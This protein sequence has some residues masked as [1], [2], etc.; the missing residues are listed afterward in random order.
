MYGCRRIRISFSE[1]NLSSQY[2]SGRPSERDIIE[3]R[4]S[5]A[6]ST[7]TNPPAVRRSHDRSSSEDGRNDRC[8]SV[9]SLSPT[10]DAA[11]ASPS[12][13]V[14]SFN[15]HFYWLKKSFWHYNS[16][17]DVAEISTWRQ[18]RQFS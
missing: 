6:R 10:N 5:A 13:T 14:R 16:I 1:I 8:Y 9:S 3:A 12:L 7:V 11:A 2:N 17:N 4:Y 15:P 18:A